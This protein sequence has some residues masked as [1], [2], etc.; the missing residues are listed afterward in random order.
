MSR[1]HWTR[2]LTGTAFGGLHAVVGSFPLP[3]FTRRAT[4]S[5]ARLNGVLIPIPALYV[6]KIRFGFSQADAAGSSPEI[7][8]LFGLG[9]GADFASFPVSFPVAGNPL[10]LPPWAVVRVDHDFG[11]GGADYE[12]NVCCSF[13]G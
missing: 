13:E 6:F 8:L 12:V 11:V 4:F 1:Q 7:R 9:G 5:V 10:V 3:P 2:V